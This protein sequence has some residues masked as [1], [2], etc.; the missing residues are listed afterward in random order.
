MYINSNYDDWRMIVE[1]AKEKSNITVASLKSTGINGKSLKSA[2][3][4]VL[5]A[6]GYTSTTK[7]DLDVLFKV[8]PNRP[9]EP[10][11]SILGIY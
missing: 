3:Y 9:S 10:V 6:D 2:M 8:F 4:S 11:T 1:Q 5:D 7:E